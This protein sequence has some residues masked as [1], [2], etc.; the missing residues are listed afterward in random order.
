M[1]QRKRP[2]RVVFY[3]NEAEQSLL[4]AKMQAAN[5]QNREAYIRKMVLDG[6]VLRLDFSDVKRM[7]FLLS[8]ATNNLNQIAKRVNESG[9]MFAE[10]VRTLREDYAQVWG[11]AKVVV[12][13]L[14]RL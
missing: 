8:N 9:S 11:V 3:L 6:Y 5:I 13:T 1:K 4:E 7:V 14:A 10:D 2:I 12:K